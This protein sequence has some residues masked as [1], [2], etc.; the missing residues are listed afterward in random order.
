[1]SLDAFAPNHIEQSPFWCTTVLIVT[2]GLK[3]SN[4]IILTAAQ[5]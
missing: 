2:A 5:G 1:M 3:L 4:G